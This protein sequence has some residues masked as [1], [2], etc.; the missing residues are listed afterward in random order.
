MAIGRDTTAQNVKPLEGAIVRRFTAG[1]T[2]AA[3]ELVSM[4]SDGKVDP[5]DSTA[6]KMPV[7]GVA[8][9]AGADGSR[10]DVVVFGPVVCLTGA[11]P[12]AVVYN[13]TTAGE[14]LESVAGNQTV[15]GLAESATVLF[16]RPASA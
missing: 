16:V 11:T 10:I 14:P 13:S 3:G 4:Q 12:G 8:I 2:V 5:S 9:G 6:A 7:L 15:A 1:A